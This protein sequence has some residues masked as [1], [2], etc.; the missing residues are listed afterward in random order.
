MCKRAGHKEKRDKGNLGKPGF[1]V[2]VYNKEG[3]H[4]VGV[5]EDT[6]ISEKEAREHAGLQREANRA[7]TTST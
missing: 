1:Y 7:S 2:A 5:L 4:K 6:L 3:K